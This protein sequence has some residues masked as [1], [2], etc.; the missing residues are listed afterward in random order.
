MVGSGDPKVEEDI[1]QTLTIGIAF[2]SWLKKQ[3]ENSL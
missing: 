1:V 3:R 2:D